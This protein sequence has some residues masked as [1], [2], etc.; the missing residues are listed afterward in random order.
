MINISQ[1]DL[2]T[3]LKWSKKRSPIIYLVLSMNGKW[4]TAKD[5]AQ[6]I[7]SNFAPLRIGGRRRPHRCIPCQCWIGVIRRGRSR[8]LGGIGEHPRKLFRDVSRCWTG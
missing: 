7:V 8:F 3:V 6:N 5:N 4:G 2:L 1:K